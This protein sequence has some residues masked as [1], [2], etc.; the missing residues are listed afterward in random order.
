MT[1]HLPLSVRVPIEQDNPSIMRDEEK[2]IKCGMC[3]NVCTEKI[4]VHGTYSFEDTNGRA[5]CINCGQCAN[6]CPV[7][8]ITEKYEYQEV[9]DAI[10]EKRGTVIVSTSPSVRVAIGEEFGLPAGTFTEGK[11]VALLKKLGVD[12]VLDTNFSADLTIVE[13][14]SEL[15][16]RIKNNG[17]L[18]QFTSCCPA[19]VK[20]V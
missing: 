19:W 13:E 4:G 1:N 10:K 2:C 3:K 17:P 5:I 7:N 9:R 16:E 15:I 12:Y 8:S 14:A 20:Y 6:V 11:M 18:P